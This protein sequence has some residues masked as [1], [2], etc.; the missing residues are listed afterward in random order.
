LFSV[1]P[2]S[3]E[4]PKKLMADFSCSRRYNTVMRPLACLL[5]VSSLLAQGGAL[6]HSHSGTGVAEPA[7]HDLKPHFHLSGCRHR[8]CVDAAAPER[9]PIAQTHRSVY[10][11]GLPS[12][13]HDHDAVYVSAGGDMNLI[14]RGA[15]SFTLAS[16]M[17]LATC[18]AR[19][20]A[21][22][23]LPQLAPVAHGDSVPI[24]LASTRLLV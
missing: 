10:C 2:A 5:L 21:S 4:S 6:P 20:G 7:G 12:C 19:P 23:I 1:A 15:A 9:L 17:Q 11:Y 3:W 16:Y 18:G 24:F 14:E 22:A 13:D 8:Q